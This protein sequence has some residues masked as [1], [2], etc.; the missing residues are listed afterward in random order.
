MSAL[1]TR[2]VQFFMQIYQNVTL[3]EK[4]RVFGKLM[5]LEWEDYDDF[6]SKYGSAS[7]PES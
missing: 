3:A 4:L 7:N 6:M 1:E 2:Q 5:E